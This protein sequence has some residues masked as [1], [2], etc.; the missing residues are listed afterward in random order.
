MLS[1]D[2]IRKELAGVP[3]EQRCAAPWGTGIYT[4]AWTERVYAELLGRAGRLLGL[5]E[6]VLADASFITSG[7]RAAAAQAAAAAHANLVQLRCT[8]PAEVAGQ[9]LASRTDGISDADTGIARQM[10][11]VEAAWTEAVTIDT[12]QLSPG[13]APVIPAEPPGAVAQQAI[14][15]IRPHQPE[16]VRRPVRPVLL[17]D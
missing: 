7:Q 3:A 9:R 8:A 15:A 11:A 17:P 13:T 12:G 6:S 14:E 1:S 10:A 5:G 4:A 16:H 2:R